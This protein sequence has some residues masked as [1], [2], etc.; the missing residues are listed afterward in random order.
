MYL[1]GF[2]LSRRFLLC[3]L[4][5]VLCL[6]G[7]Y[8]WQSLR[9]ELQTFQTQ[10]EK[11]VYVRFEMEAYDSIKENYWKKADD[12]DLAQLFQLSLAKAAN[13]ANPPIL[14]TNDR[15]GTAKMFADSFSSATST[16]AR[17]RL[18]LNSLIVALYNLAP[19]G[20][21]NLFSEQ[22]EI[23]MRQEVAN[24][25]RGVDLYGNL[26]LPKGASVTDIDGAYKKKKMELEQTA[27][28]EAKIELEKLSYAHKV[29]ANQENKSRYDEW[30]VEPTVFPRVIGS[31]LYIYISKISPSTLQEFAKAIDNATTTPN[32]KS[33]ILDLR[34]NIGGSLDFP[35]YFLGLF[36]GQNQFAFDLFKQGDYVP[37]RTMIGKFD[38]LSRYNEI[39]ILTDGMTQSTAEVITAM[40]K[41]FNLARVVG[42]STRGW[43][44]VE[45]TFP[46]QTVI[47]PSEKYSL[48]LVRYLTLR[49]DGQ[50]IEGV[51]V[52]ADVNTGDKDWRSKLVTHFRSQALIDAILQVT[53][54]P[55]SR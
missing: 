21:N 42:T 10:E 16:E 52:D 53:S 20:R 1:F 17:K 25:N 34:G 28:P 33:M 41:R 50:P 22:Q 9:V 27:T 44:T 30:Q 40:F 24:V 47:D 46:I 15:S 7:Y 11:D 18:A 13:L 29:L 38:E 12:A 23:A 51:G 39:A 31:T 6:G 55:P 36:I 48:L 35:A 2:L 3:S 43:G 5:I 45:N 19:A 8:Y 49:D 26:G 32:L 4:A 14:V 54:K 37:Q